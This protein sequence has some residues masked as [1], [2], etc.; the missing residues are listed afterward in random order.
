MQYTLRNVPKEVD[1][2]L[3]ETARRE[4]KSLSAVALEALARGAGIDD[5]DV[6]KRDLG[7]FAGS[8]VRDPKTDDALADQRRIDPSLWK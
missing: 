5:S 6:R 7:R 8:W 1:R 4:G 3:R 2:A